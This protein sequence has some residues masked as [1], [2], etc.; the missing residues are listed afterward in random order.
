MPQTCRESEDL[1]SALPETDWVGQ[2]ALLPV[3]GNRVV[4]I[5]GPDALDLL[6]R[7]TTNEMRT[8]STERAVVTALLSPVGKLRNLFTVVK[9]EDG[10]L[11]LAGPGESESLRALLQSQIFFMD[12]AK[13]MDVSHEWV[14]FQVAGREA[15]RAVTSLGFEPGCWQEGL[16][17]RSGKMLAFLQERLEWPSI[18]LVL[19]ANAVEDA[20]TALIAA[21]VKPLDNWSPFNLQ[22][23]LAKRAGYAGELSGDFN[24]LEVGLDW[25]CAENKG[26]YPGQEI[27]AR[28][29][30]Y[31]KITRQLVLLHSI[32]PLERKA[33]VK[34]GKAKVGYVS[35][36]EDLKPGGGSYG[37]A[38]LR[39]SSIAGIEH[40][41]VSGNRASI[42]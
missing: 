40:V 6:Q 42:C 28:Q 11:L 16:V 37:L 41:T 20:R 24:P 23:I 7:L 36:K 39:S 27:I 29:I 14:V 30:T 26:C 10:Y 8:V 38:V 17:Q 32:E 12:N 18:Y 34:V 33:N 21:E 15:G 9:S 13:V 5:A 22:R 19:P 2:A 1:N 25:I 35:S 4:G 3:R 31:G